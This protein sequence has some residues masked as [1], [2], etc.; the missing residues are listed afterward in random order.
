MLTTLLAQFNTSYWGVPSALDSRVH[1]QRE[2]RFKY[3][4]VFA[5]TRACVR[6]T[7]AWPF[8]CRFIHGDAN[9]YLAAP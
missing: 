4:R 3:A 7:T 8:E 6:H 1:A 5:C 9:H 2:G